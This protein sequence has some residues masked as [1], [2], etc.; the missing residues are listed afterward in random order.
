MPPRCC[1]VNKVCVLLQQLAIIKRDD[2]RLRGSPI[3]SDIDG[4]N[5][6]DNSINEEISVEK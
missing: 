6:Q 2:A 1:H 4:N 3:V 5:A